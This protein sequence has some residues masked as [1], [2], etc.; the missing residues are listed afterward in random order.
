M[1]D[2]IKMDLQEIGCGH[3]LDWS[4][5]GYGQVT[6]CCERDDKFG[7]L[8]MSRIYW[9]SEQLL[10]SEPFWGRT[11]LGPSEEELFSKEVAR[12]VVSDLG[13]MCFWKI[14]FIW[15][16]CTKSRSMCSDKAAFNLSPFTTYYWS[17]C[18]VLEGW[19]C[20]A[21]RGKWHHWW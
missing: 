2:N 8:K 19:G 20:A 10:A 4:A 12:Y 13:V 1:G 9:L 11:L 7:F 17:Y 21:V 6:S 16:C 18:E 5:S 14:S 3:G 15:I